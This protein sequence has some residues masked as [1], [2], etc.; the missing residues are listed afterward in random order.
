MEDDRSETATAA[1]IYDKLIT[2]DKVEAILGPYALGL[3]E[4]VADVAEKHRRP[5]VAPLASTSSIF[6][7]GRKFVFMMLSPAEV[8][9]EGLIDMAAKRGLR[10]LAV[11]NEDTLFPRAWHRAPLSWPRNGVSRSF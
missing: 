3:S 9:F 5:M 11:I 6:K 10:T 1:R 8:F 7:K 2:Q 4:A